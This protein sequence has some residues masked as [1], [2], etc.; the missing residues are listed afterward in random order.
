MSAT[1]TDADHPTDRRPERIVRATPAEHRFRAATVDEALAQVRASL[2]ED[3]EIVEANRIR[4]GGIGGFFATELGVEVVA[5]SGSTDDRTDVF[6]PFDDLRLGLA[7]PAAT[8]PSARPARSAPAPRAWTVDNGL[9]GFAATALDTVS[10]TVSDARV[11]A[12]PSMPAARARQAW[13]DATRSDAPEP[14][15]QLPGFEQPSIV[16]PAPKPTTFAEHFL[17]ELVQDAEQLRRSTDRNRMLPVRDAVDETTSGADDIVPPRRRTAAMAA[18]AGATEPMGRQEPLAGITTPTVARTAVGAAPAA[19][20]D[21]IRVADT[22]PPTLPGMPAPAPKRRA[23]RSGTGTT[24]ST[25]ARKAAA[26]AA[27]AEAAAAEAA[28]AAVA[29]PPAGSPARAMIGELI[30]QCVALTSSA[31]ASVAP[32]KIALA[33]TLPDGSVMKVSI[34]A[35]RRAGRAGRDAAGA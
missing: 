10:G 15:A 32:S 14:E 18:G 6:E 19:P 7:A 28:A 2:G 24:K 1:R 23:K 33:V 26:E 11:V 31:D 35:P 16:D 34:E 21:A 5:R 22:E 13:R 3:A 30:D 9:D 25:A 17:H 29:S 4:R 8:P 12:D 27:A 20:I